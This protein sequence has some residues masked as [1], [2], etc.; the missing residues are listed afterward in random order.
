MRPSLFQRIEDLRPSTTVA[1]VVALLGVVAGLDIATGAEVSFSLFYLAPVVV[2][3]IRWGNGWGQAAAIAAAAVWYLID[4]V[5]GAQYSH[6]L[7]PVWNAGVRF[8][9]FGLVSVLA[10]GLYTVV[11][12]ET[13]LARTDSLTGLPNR[14]ALM[15]LAGREL[16]RAERQGSTVAVAVIDLDDFKSVNDRFGHE[17]GDRVLCG[18]AEVARASLRSVDITAR[19]G[20]DE[21]TVILPGIDA[22][23]AGHVLD[24]LRTELL[25]RV[26]GAIRC[27]IG[28]ASA[29]DGDLDSLLAAADA[30]LYQAKRGGRATTVVADVAA[31]RR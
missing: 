25:G 31:G 22:V 21:F 27:S 12:R 1:L 29:T 9:F 2:I 4:H 28:V 20:G 5:S 11:Q 23:A 24:R 8:G 7:I 26:E 10:G 30:A 18:F 17:A 15:E 14:R 19:T 6:P 3:T 16:D 13:L